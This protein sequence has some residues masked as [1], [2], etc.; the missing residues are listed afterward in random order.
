MDF[1]SDSSHSDAASP[2]SIYPP[3]LDD[4]Y[5]K[6]KNA[7]GSLKNQYGTDIYTILNEARSLY[8]ATKLKESEADDNI[9]K[10]WGFPSEKDDSL[11]F[12]TVSRK[13]RIKSPT[14]PH[15]ASSA[16]KQRTDQSTC[17]NKYSSLSVE[18]SPEKDEQFSAD[19]SDMEQTDD[20]PP[21]ASTPKQYIRP[22]P[23]ITIDNV[24]QS[25]QFLKSSK[26]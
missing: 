8:R 21:R 7:K 17:Q 23:S 5:D 12:K 11:D 19:H 10:K 25:E 13:T 15:D 24:D 4:L 1:E 6:L 20:P 26:N 18:E 14:L 16:K 2:A 3:N 22:P 9:F